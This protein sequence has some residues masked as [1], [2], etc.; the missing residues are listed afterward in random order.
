LFA[1]AVKVATP[2]AAN[3]ETT[4]TVMARRSNA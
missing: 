4:T 3:P 2:T 1:E